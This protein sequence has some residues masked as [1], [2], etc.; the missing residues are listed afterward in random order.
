[1]MDFDYQQHIKEKAGVIN[2]FHYK[3]F[4]H[5]GVAFETRIATYSCPNRTLASHTEAQDHKKGT[6]CEVRGFWG[7][8][9]NS[10]YH[11]FSTTTHAED[12]RRLFKISGS[13]YKHTETDIAEFNLLSYFSQM[14]TGEEM[15]LPAEKPEELVFPYASPLEELR[16]ADSKPKV[17]EVIEE[18]EEEEKEKESTAKFSPPARQRGRRAPKKASWPPL[19]PAFEEGVEVVLLAGDLREVLKKSRYHG[20]FHRAFIGSMGVLPIFE[21]M[22]LTTAGEDPFRPAEGT[23]QKIRKPPMRSDPE[24]LGKKRAESALA[25]CMADGAVIVCETMKYQA[26]YEARARLAFRHRM[27]QVGHLAGW[28]LMDTKHALPRM[29]HDMKEKKCGELE[30]DATDFLRFVAMPAP[31]AAA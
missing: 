9:I 22:G 10:P 6:L 3:E 26:H 28:R 4:C 16:T 1:L 14:E 8:I 25:G 27:A 15:H 5:T 7:D 13:M 20:K 18:E 30:K 12:K 29:E 23:V 31:S 17:C 11:A 2:W 19:V 24:L 21:E